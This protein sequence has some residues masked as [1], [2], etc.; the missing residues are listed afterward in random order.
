[1]T[2]N[3][4]KK[5]L[6]AFSLLV[7]TTS[8]DMLEDE[9]YNPDKVTDPKFELFFASSLQQSHLFRMEYGPTYHYLRGFTKMMGIGVNPVFTDVKQFNEP[10]KTWTGWSGEPFNWDIFRKTNVQFSKDINAMH[11]LYKN[12]SEEDKASNKIYI[13]CSDVVK[14]YAFQRS[15]D[16][17]DDI[18]YFQVGGAFQE[19]FYA[20][21]D[22]QEAI[23]TDLLE[24]LANTVKEL[25]GFEFATSGQKTKFTSNDI[26][27][28]GDIDKWIRFANSLRLRM[29]MR[30]CH[31]KPEVAKQII[32][33]VIVDGRIVMET[34][35]NIEFRE[36]NKLNVYSELFY[37]GFD[38]RGWDLIAPKFYIQ[39]LFNYHDKPGDTVD[40]RLYVIFQ[41]NRDGEY[42]GFPVTQVKSNTDAY[43]SQYYTPE[44]ID[45]I[46]KNDDAKIGAWDPSRLVTRYNRATFMNFDMDFPVI[47]A[48]EVLLLL[49]EAAVRWPGEFGSINPAEYLKQAIISSSEFYYKLNTTNTYN[50]STV[51]DLQ[52]VPASARVK[53]LDYDY[54]HKYVDFA[55]TRFNSMNQLEKMNHLLHQKLIHYNI[56]NPYEGFNEIRRLIKDNSGN[57]P[58]TPM[59]NVYWCERFF[60]PSEEA[61]NNA[62]N[63]EAVKHKNNYTTPVWW[64]GR[65]TYTLNPNAT[66]SL[67]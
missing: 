9:F 16:L 4:L 67:E 56:L 59:V 35:Q 45:S 13:L 53:A 63:F 12:M 58:I 51:P 31:V 65:T 14:A 27:N 25:D 36:R 32:K 23:Y 38:E 42:I 19:Q 8:C 20:A 7:G 29:A 61:N 49:A 22:S 26:L 43:L 17:Y 3:I 24:K 60:Y 37:R 2:T 15:T 44:Q 50:E 57:L 62:E 55:A 18:P 41:P 21:F 30:L 28:G 11:L 48:P 47:Q 39:D 54:L 33:E 34:S 46:Y 40:P 66:V 10:V 6:F 52:H 64:S 5:G 1:M